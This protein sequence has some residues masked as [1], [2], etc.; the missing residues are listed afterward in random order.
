LGFSKEEY[1]EV[2]LNV[3]EA[4]KQIG[5]ACEA[6]TTFHS[7]VLVESCDGKRN[8]MPYLHIFSSDKTEIDKIIMIFIQYQIFFD[9]ESSTG[10]FIEAVKTEKEWRTALN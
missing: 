7:D 8:S 3:D 6:V 4:L 9:I 1:E 2:K 10:N 5:L